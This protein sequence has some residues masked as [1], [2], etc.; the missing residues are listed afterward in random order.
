MRFNTRNIRETIDS[1][2]RGH[3]FHLFNRYVF[4]LLK[5]C[6]P[7]PKLSLRLDLFSTF[8]GVHTL[9]FTYAPYIDIGL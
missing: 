7:R 4:I 5:K 2:A 1:F 3:T 6:G 9:I 8:R